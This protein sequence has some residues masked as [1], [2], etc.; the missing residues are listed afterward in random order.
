MNSRKKVNYVCVD[1]QDGAAVVIKWH[2][3]KM[4]FFNLM[5]NQTIC[6]IEMLSLGCHLMMMVFLCVGKN[7]I[8]YNSKLY[9]IKVKL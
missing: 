2:I 4:V 7:K 3:L 6:L 5:N 8:S 9:A 1:A